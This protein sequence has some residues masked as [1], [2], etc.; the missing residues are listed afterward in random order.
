MDKRRRINRLERMRIERMWRGIRCRLLLYY[1]RKYGWIHL[2]YYERHLIYLN[3]ILAENRRS[4]SLNPWTD[5]AL[6]D[7]VR[8]HLLGIHVTAHMDTITVIQIF[9]QALFLPSL[10]NLLKLLDKNLK[11]LFQPFL[12]LPC[13]A[14]LKSISE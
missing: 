14:L 9:V 10:N 6:T 7:V 12:R 5:A 4:Y 8:C 1:V 2:G 13:Q 3:P 11:L